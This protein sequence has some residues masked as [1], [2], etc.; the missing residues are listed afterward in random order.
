MIAYTSRFERLSWP[1]L[2]SIML[3]APLPVAGSEPIQPSLRILDDAA[4]RR[5]TIV[6]DRVSCCGADGGP[7]EGAAALAQ[8]VMV[9]RITVDLLHGERRP[10]EGSGD[11]ARFETSLEA[12]IGAA[13]M[14][15]DFSPLIRTL[16]LPRPLGLRLLAGDSLWVRAR[17]HS[18]AGS[19]LQLRI[20]LDYSPL[21]GP[22]S[23][24]AVLPVQF[25]ATG[26]SYEWV[27]PVAGRLMALAGLPSGMPGELLIQDVE[28]GETLWRSPLR[29]GTDAFG[30][31]SDVAHVGTRVQAGRRYRLTLQFAGGDA[32]P[33]PQHV[34]HSLVLAM[35]S[36]ERI[37]N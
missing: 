26:A 4:Q 28:T 35:P 12:R 19:G 37:R 36:A 5:L 10:G 21:D 16:D 18:A 13:T 25:T 3:S 20:T 7:F 29:S 6:V 8:S 33:A 27:A 24:L 23:R 30:G 14:V 1:L 31:R 34:V 11:G 2:A 9:H 32:D 15:L 22:A 17:L